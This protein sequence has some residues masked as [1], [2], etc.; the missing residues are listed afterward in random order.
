[1]IAAQIIIPH[2]ATLICIVLTMNHLAGPPAFGW[3]LT[4]ATQRQRFVK[5][6]SF[7]RFVRCTYKLFLTL[8]LRT[9]SQSHR[10]PHLSGDRSSP[11]RFGP[12]PP[13]NR[14]KLML[15]IDDYIIN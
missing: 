5:V 10:L 1:L 9:P 12:T 11:T 13:A 2:S 3:A 15:A 8:L 14:Q 6:P 4:M 7:N